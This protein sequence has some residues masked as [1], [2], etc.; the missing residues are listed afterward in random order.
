MVNIYHLMTH[1][2]YQYWSL[3]DEKD[4]E[5]WHWKFRSKCFH[6]SYEQK[7]KNEINFKSQILIFRELKRSSCPPGHLKDKM[8]ATLSSLHKPEMPRDADSDFAEIN[9]LDDI[10]V[11]DQLV[12]K[13]DVRK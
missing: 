7:E 6:W 9:P 11:S 3:K 10:D 8:E 4:I 12:R 1:F 13:K 2:Q 5:N